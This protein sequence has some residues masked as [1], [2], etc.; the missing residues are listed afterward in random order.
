MTSLLKGRK[1]QTN[2]QIH[3]NPFKKRFIDGSSGCSTFKS[4]TSVLTTTKEGVQKYCE[5]VYSHIII[6][7]MWI[8][9]SIRLFNSLHYCS[10]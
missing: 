2:K 1:T 4:L 10:T 3:K 7:Q 9:L 8:A 5:V 6:N